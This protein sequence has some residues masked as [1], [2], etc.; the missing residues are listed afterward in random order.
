MSPFL[1]CALL[2][3]RGA[4]A[5]PR[6]PPLP[7][8]TLPLPPVPEH[9]AAAAADAWAAAAAFAAAAN[10]GFCAPGDACW[11]TAAQWASLNASVGG[12]L[13]ALR[14]EG[15]PCV[16]APASPACAQVTAS[17]TN[18]SWRRAQPGASQYPQW[19]ADAR[20]GA[21]CWTPGAPCSQGN[22]P[23]YAVAARAAADVAAALRFAQAHNLRVVV[24]ASGHDMQGRSAGADALLVW[25]A[26]L[27]AVAVH[28]AG[29]FRACAGDAA[30]AAVTAQPGA[31][32]G[33]LQA[34]LGGA[35]VIVTGS[36]RTVSAAGGHALGGGHSYASPAYGLAADNLLAAQV[37]LANGSIVTASACSHAD[38][39]WALRGGGGSSVG[40][41]LN[42]TYRLHPNPPEGVTGME[43]G[44]EFKQGVVSADLLLQLLFSSSPAL[45]D[46]AR[47][48]GGVW[49]G[50]WFLMPGPAGSSPAS[51]AALLVFNGSQAAAQ[52]SIASVVARLAGDPAQ[53]SI[54]TLAFTPYANMNAFHE[55]IDPPPGET[56]GSWSVWGS[57]LLP[58]AAVTDA[59]RLANVSAA[60]A[61]A[62]QY[63]RVLGHL[64]AG[65]A[66]AAADPT[67]AATALTPAWRTAV[68]HL[69]IQA[70]FASNASV[71][72]A[73][74][75]FS[76]VSYLTGLL[77]AALPDSGAYWNEADYLE[78]AWQQTFWGGNYP[79]LQRVKAAYDPL[80]RF[81]CWHCVELPAARPPAAGGG[82]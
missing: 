29:A 38:L 42:A 75:T 43:L 21:N 30:T 26:A 14:P 24:K 41:V 9:A 62:A 67:G 22:V 59:A 35:F 79:R 77:R 66:V 18:A 19:E 53:F 8:S 78:P 27:D 33:E 68:G 2:L 50:Y 25:L 36:A 57:R 4:S 70:D 6:L 63:V 28:A 61:T 39:F 15:A 56:T 54:V 60:L 10:A 32:A 55:A 13:L 48:S 11:P 52:A 45:L 65:G 34:A 12:S 69:L 47:S 49:G 23:P 80:G 64:V 16:A 58:I 72:E 37:A 3:L 44:V 71:P 1:V 40:V 82:E 5:R 51:F 76:A 31:T 17:W 74:S 7:P 73:Q 20:T 81:S 46:P